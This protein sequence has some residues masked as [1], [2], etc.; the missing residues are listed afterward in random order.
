LKDASGAV[1]TIFTKYSERLPIWR[2]LDLKALVETNYMLKFV[3][4][5]PCVF[6]ALLMLSSN[7]LGSK[8]ESSPWKPLQPNESYAP[9]IHT[10]SIEKSGTKVTVWE[11]WMYHEKQNFTLPPETG[12][13]RINSIKRKVQYDCE[14]KTYRR[15][16]QSGYPDILGH[17]EPLYSLGPT[18]A[19]PV[20][21]DTRA[22]QLLDEACT[23]LE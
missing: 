15:I 19:Q 20:P 9:Y 22:E 17:A 16:S 13:Y 23:F 10:P 18:L 5:I 6:A 21:P 11:L 1:S 12:Q 4:N 14:K 2:R 8:G 7:A 3:P